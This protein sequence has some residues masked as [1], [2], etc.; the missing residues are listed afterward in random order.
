MFLYFRKWSYLA[1]RLKT[2]L[3]FFRKIHFYIS[4]G[5]SKAQKAKGSYPSPKNVRNKF[6]QNYFRKIVFNFS[7]NWINQYY[8]YVKTL[9]AFFWVNFF[10]AFRYFLLNISSLIF[11][12]HYNANFFPNFEYSHLVS[13]KYLLYI[14]SFFGKK[15]HKGLIFVTNK[16]FKI[17]LLKGSLLDTT[18]SLMSISF[19]ETGLLC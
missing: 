19:I 18:I 3:Y 17:F 12:F 6:F 11:L 1:P 10:S 7:I 8:C 9:K 15:M 16:V 13:S 2:L 4:V 14:Y 5:T